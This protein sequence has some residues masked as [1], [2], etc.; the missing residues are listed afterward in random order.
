MMMMMMMMMMRLLLRLLL[1][2][3]CCFATAD[4]CLHAYTIAALLGDF[5]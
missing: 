4:G 2:W 5:F 1:L 3:F